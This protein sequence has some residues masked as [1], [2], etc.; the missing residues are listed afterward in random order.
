MVRT[1]HSEVNTC[2]EVR[3]LP[4]AFLDF[5]ESSVLL[6]IKIHKIIK[7]QLVA[8]PNHI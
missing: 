4:V 2:K 7:G 5:I 8:I 1:E 3:K 6:I